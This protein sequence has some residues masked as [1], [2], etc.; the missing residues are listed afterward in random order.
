MLIIILYE[1]K[2]SFIEVVAIIFLEQKVLLL[3]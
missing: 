3:S 1:N 2:Y